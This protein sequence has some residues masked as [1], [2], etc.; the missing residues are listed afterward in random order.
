VTR[1]ELAAVKALRAATLRYLRALR[2]AEE[3]LDRSDPAGAYVHD[4]VHWALTGQSDGTPR[5]LARVLD[6]VIRHGGE[7]PATN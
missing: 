2:V 7:L 3:A 6:E 4:Q 1:E 5:T